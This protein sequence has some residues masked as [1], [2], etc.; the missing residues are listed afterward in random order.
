MPMDCFSSSSSSSSSLSWCYYCTW[1]CKRFVSW[2]VHSENLADIALK[3]RKDHL[4]TKLVISNITMRKDKQFKDWLPIGKVSLLNKNIVNLC[5]EHNL[6]LIKQ[7]NIKRKLYLNKYGSSMLAKIF[8][9]LLITQQ[10]FYENDYKTR[11]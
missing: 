6:D 5:V 8:Q 2:S 1:R 7:Y 3:I 9:I 4:N 11:K 10:M